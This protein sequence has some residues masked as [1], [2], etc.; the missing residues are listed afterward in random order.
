MGIILVVAIFAGTF[1]LNTDVMAEPILGCAELE[2]RENRESNQVVIC[3]EIEFNSE[4]SIGGLVLREF[5]RLQKDTENHPCLSDRPEAYK[6]VKFRVKM[7]RLGY[8]R[9]FLLLA[10]ISGEKCK[11]L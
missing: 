3:R 10:S 8:L 4:D 6:K 7:S 9:S 5:E 1:F 11:V 2:A